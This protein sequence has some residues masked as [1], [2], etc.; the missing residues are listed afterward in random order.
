MLSF[1]TGMDSSVNQ[2]TADDC[3]LRGPVEGVPSHQSKNPQK[4][5]AEFNK[6]ARDRSG[7]FGLLSTSAS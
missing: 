7:H 6:V 1:E 2:V 3:K 4:V 5:A